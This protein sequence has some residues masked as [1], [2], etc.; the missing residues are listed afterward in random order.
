LFPAKFAKNYIVRNG[1]TLDLQPDMFHSKGA[2]AGHVGIIGGN[3]QIFILMQLWRLEMI[4]RWR[5]VAGL[6]G[7]LGMGKIT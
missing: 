3:A 6:L 7:S 2:G 1:L 5:N 4:N